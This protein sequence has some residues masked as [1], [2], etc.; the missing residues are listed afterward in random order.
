[1]SFH[2]GPGYLQILAD[3]DAGNFSGETAWRLIVGFPKNMSHKPFH[4]VTCRFSVFQYI[5][6][7]LNDTDLR[8]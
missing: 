2:D 4:F 8:N 6:R 7:N 3:T 1:M 5:G